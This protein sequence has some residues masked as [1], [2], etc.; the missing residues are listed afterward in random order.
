MSSRLFYH[1]NVVKFL[2][3]VGLQSLTWENHPSFTCVHRQIPVF[4]GCCSHRFG[5][6][7]FS[8]GNGE[9][10]IVHPQTTTT[11]P[12]SRVLP[13]SG[14]LSS[15]TPP[16]AHHTNHLPTTPSPYPYTLCSRSLH[17]P[18]RGSL[19]RV[20]Q[21]FSILLQHHGLLQI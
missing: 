19:L 18:W 7:I 5:E 9:F 10:T 20:F 17:Q 16:P 14:N 8:H 13:T 3:S 6:L 21:D 2:L 12:I 11:L 1:W 4:R 15:Y